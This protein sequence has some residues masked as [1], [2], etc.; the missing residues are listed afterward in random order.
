M[1]ADPVAAG[2]KGGQSRSA[3]KLA[4]IKRNGFQRVNPAPVPPAAAA[5]VPRTKPVV[6]K[7]TAPA[8]KPAAV[9]QPTPTPKLSPDFERECR[10]QLGSDFTD[11]KPAHFFAVP[12]VNPKGRDVLPEQ[13]G[14]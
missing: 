2:R 7:R 10:V 1:P 13:K 8:P 14:K 12:H 6:E 4:A 3:A 11:A 5:P 9:P